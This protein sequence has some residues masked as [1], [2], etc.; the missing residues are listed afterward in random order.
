MTNF[1]DISHIMP[2]MKAGKEL[3]SALKV[4]PAYNDAIRS[5]SAPE[6]LIALSDLYQIYVPTQMS[7]EIYSKLYLALLRSLQKKGTK[8]AVKQQ[9]Q[10][11]RAIMQ[12]DYSGI[13]GGADS[14][15]II[16]ESGIGKSSAIK[17]AIALIHEN[18]VWET[19]HPYSKIVPCIC[20]QCPFDSSVKGFMLE[21]LRKT[22][23]I[24]ER[25]DYWNAL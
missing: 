11:F 23:E 20:V 18:S 24:L 8:L 17:R 15:T 9:N 7:V 4:L 16:G 6:R 22:D 1:S 14:F 21:I 19:S 12:Q 10:N 13:I 25:K 2:P 3:L 5:A